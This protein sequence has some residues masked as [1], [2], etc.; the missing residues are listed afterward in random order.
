MEHF[1]I[2]RLQEAGYMP[3]FEPGMFQTNR[4]PAEQGVQGFMPMHTPEHFFDAVDTEDHWHTPHPY[5]GPNAP[6]STQTDA[7]VEAGTG[8]DRPDA[9]RDQPGG[10]LLLIARL[11]DYAHC[12]L[13][14]AIQRSLVSRPL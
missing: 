9:D 2:G 7:Y 6:R 8:S 13:L 5:A 10:R 1:H 4:D 11:A 12:E 3:R 14:F